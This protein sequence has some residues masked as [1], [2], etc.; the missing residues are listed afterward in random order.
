MKEN[1]K[2][3]TQSWTGSDTSS[4]GQLFSEPRS[5]AAGASKSN[6]L[7]SLTSIRALLTG[8]LLVVSRVLLRCQRN[9]ERKTRSA[10][11]PIHWPNFNGT[12]LNQTTNDLSTHVGI[13]SGIGNC[14][15]SVLGNG[16][17]RIE[18]ST[19]LTCSGTTK[20]S[21]SVTRI[22]DLLSRFAQR[23]GFL[24]G[25]IESRPRQSNCLG[26]RLRSSN[27]I[28]NCSGSTGCRGTT[29]ATIKA[30]GS[31]TISFLS[32]LSTFLNQ[33]TKDAA[34]TFQ[35]CVRYVARR[36]ERNGPDSL[37]SILKLYAIA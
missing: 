11:R 28:W 37:P 21:I 33:T 20:R 9:G 1:E 22:T 10:P 34:S 32:R 6:R 25:A 8:F 7:V 27:V 23:F 18:T 36:I 12:D 2:V 35:T 17:K 5:D 14:R 30:V 31:L 13:F 16:E 26:V 29:T 24:C 4:T 15:R 19:M 3:K